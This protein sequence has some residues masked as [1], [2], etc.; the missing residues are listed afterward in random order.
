MIPVNLKLSNFTSY[1]ADVPK[2]E[3]TKF[4]LAAVSGQNGAGK[5]SLLD[6][7]TWC[8]WGVSRLGDSSD[9]LVH[10][11]Q[12]QMWVEFSF[13]L[14]EH[15]FTIRRQRVLKSGGS[16][17]LELLSNSSAKGGTQH[18]LTEGT[19]KATQQKITDILHLSYETFVNSA[20]LRQ[21]HADEF[22][23]RG[24]SD[25]KRILADILGLSHYDEL[26]EKSKEKAKEAQSKLQL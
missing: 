26:E 5:S 25:R 1:G 24:P 8:V 9:Q 6:S 23:T 22:T 18:N 2:L 7:I 17:S 13:K 11:G 20:F 3:F 15:T 4:H 16:T 21:G 14:D 19:I 10:L 12:T